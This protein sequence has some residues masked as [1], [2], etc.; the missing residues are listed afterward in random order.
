MDGDASDWSDVLSGVR[1]G[2]VLGPLLFLTFINDISFWFHLFVNSP[3]RQWLFYVPGSQHHRRLYRTPKK[4]WTHC[5]HEPWKWQMKFNSNKCHVMQVSYRRNNISFDYHPGKDNLTSVSEH[6]Y[7]GL[8]FTSKPSWKSHISNITLKANRM[9]GLIKRNSRH[10]H[11]RLKKQAYFS[12]VHS[13]LEYCSSVW[14]PP[15]I[16]LNVGFR[17][18]KLC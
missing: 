14:N 12:L 16:K 1:Q 15:L 7:L 13:H 4:I 10:C 11:P 9:L 3:L 5:T 6:P 17:E 18:H 2:T 8:T